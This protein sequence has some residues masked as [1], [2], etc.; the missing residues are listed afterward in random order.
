MHE[1]DREWILLILF[2]SAPWII[3]IGN[4]DSP[5]EIRWNFDNDANDANDR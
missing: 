1:G 4:G 3:A 5:K 2:S